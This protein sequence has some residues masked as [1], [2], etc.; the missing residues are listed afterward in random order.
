M[1][2][3]KINDLLPDEMLRKVF[4]FLSPPDLKSSVLVC[5]RWEGLLGFE[6][7][8]TEHSARSGAQINLT[9]AEPK[10]QISEHKKAE[11]RNICKSRFGREF[12]KVHSGVRP[13]RLGAFTNFSTLLDMLRRNQFAS[14]DEVK[15]EA[16]CFLDA[17]VRWFQNPSNGEKHRR[18]EM[19]AMAENL[20]EMFLNLVDDTSIVQSTEFEIV[21]KLVEL[22]PQ[23]DHIEL[24][25]RVNH[26]LSKSGNKRDIDVAFAV[27]EISQEIFDT[28]TD[29]DV[30]SK[31]H[32]EE[33][34]SH[35]DVAVSQVRK[36]LLPGWEVSTIEC[37]VHQKTLD[38]FNSKKRFFEENRRGFN[39]DG[40]V[41][42]L[43]LFHGTDASKIDSI[44]ENNFAI[45][46]VPKQRKKKM[47][48]GL[49]YYGRGVYM[50]KH[51][52][53]ALGY[54]DTLLLCR[55]SSSL[56]SSC[57]YVKHILI[58]DIC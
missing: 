6:T 30:D 22:F 27:I 49:P 38:T 24:H 45:D 14:V 13:R 54:G 40:K 2:E 16:V 52:Q 8:Q 29:F 1:E 25:R 58:C 19:V 4:S 31:V 20:K 18:N 55:V 9:T 15:E 35:F 44:V 37:V 39:G 46:A 50:S 7:H 41:E 5:R 3:D 28:E 36:M 53:I 56:L 11:I 10:S 42:E 21:E 43:L 48:F 47:A 12:M 51:P 33:D 26:Y 57:S 23:L 34:Q 32:N 17:Q